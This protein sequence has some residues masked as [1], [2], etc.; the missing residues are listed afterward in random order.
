MF[1]DQHLL[2]EFNNGGVNAPPWSLRLSLTRPP[3][4]FSDP[5][6]GRTDFNQITIAA[7]GTKD[8][9]FPRPVLLTTYDER[10]ET[11]LT[12]NWNLTLER[13]FLPQWLARAGLRRFVV[14]VRA[15]HQ[16]AKS[17]AAQHGSLLRCPPTCSLRSLVNIEFFDQDRRANYHSMQLSM[18]KR[19]SQNYTIL[20]NYTWAKG[21]GTYF[22]ETQVSGSTYGEVVPWNVPDVDRLMHGPMEFDHR[23][24]VVGS[25]VW[26]LPKMNTDSGVLKKLLHGWQ[27]EWRRP[28]PDWCA[29]QRPKWSR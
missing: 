9:P 26:D 29:L 1:Y 24:R 13:E 6:L 17:G 23:H 3:G 7:I 14:D 2:G 16:A 15:D 12:Y 20:A 27:V 5:Y 18:T 10:H 25:W 11:P 28:I 8:A 19:F 4:P 22:G 21:L